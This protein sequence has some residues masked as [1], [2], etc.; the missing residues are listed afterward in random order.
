MAEAEEKKAYDLDFASIP[1]FN[2]KNNAKFHERVQEDTIDLCI[3]QQE[4][5]QSTL[6]KDCRNSY[7]CPSQN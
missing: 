6:K 3:Q 4:L 1:V 2:G 5:V 7:D